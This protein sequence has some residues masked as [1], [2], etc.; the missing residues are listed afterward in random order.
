MITRENYE[1]FF[2][3]Y[4]DN[5]LPAETRLAVELFVSANPDLGEELETLLQCR[6]EPDAHAVFPD[7]RSLVQ[8]EES[9]L[10]Y[11]DGELDE[12]GRKTVEELASREA[13][14]GLELD[15][16]LIT[17]SR[18]DTSIL[19]PGKESLYHPVKRRRVVMMPWLEAT[20]AAAVFGVVVVLLLPHGHK[21]GLKATAVVKNIRTAVTP[22]DTSSLY[23]GRNAS[24]VTPP[25]NSTLPAPAVAENATRRTNRV[26]PATHAAAVSTQVARTDASPASSTAPGEATTMMGATA[27]NTTARA[28]TTT[29]PGSTSTTNPAT[30]SDTTTQTQPEKAAAVSL[31]AVNIPKDQ[32]SFATQQLL[33]EAQEEGDGDMAGSSPPTTGKT[34]LRSLFRRVTRTL[35]KTADRDDDGGREVSISV[36]QVALK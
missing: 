36:F 14:I 10:L 11:V 7:S 25:N 32:R 18:P 21:T 29:A 3:S 34:K 4:V 15:R 22:P 26:R 16:L 20:A 31:A 13:R 1:E 2:L 12:T 35:G 5:E 28:T 9:L 8:Y 30:A 27:T 6:L 33:R 23:S 17:V 19:F 24:T